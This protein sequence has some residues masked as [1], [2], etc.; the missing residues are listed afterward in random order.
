[1]GIWLA[2]FLTAVVVIAVTIGCSANRGNYDVTM[3]EGYNLWQAGAVAVVDVRTPE[4]YAVGHIPGVPLIPLQELR[5]RSA[6]VPRDKQVLIICRSG[7]RSA[8]AVRLLREQGLTNVYN[9]TGGMNA[10]P[11]PVETTSK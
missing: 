11:G 1:M 10:W 2:A 4:E 3:E 6:E 7:N 9:F 5:Q 8:E